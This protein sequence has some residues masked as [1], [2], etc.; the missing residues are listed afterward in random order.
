M[1][2]DKKPVPK[3]VLVFGAEARIGG[4]LAEFLTREA[5]SVRLRLA[6]NV[7]SSVD[8]LKARY[9]NAEVVVADYSDLETLRPAVAG[10][11]GV[12]VLTPSG[13]DERSMMTNLVTALKEAGVVVHVI[14]LVG[15]QPESNM[16]RIPQALRDHGLALPI[17]HPI[18]KTILDDSGLPVTYLNSGATF[19]DNFYWMAKPLREQR[20]LIWPERKIPYIDPREIG[21]AAGRLL[22]SD[23]LRH[24]GQFHTMN[25][26]HDIMLFSQAAKLMSEVWGEPIAYEGSREAFFSAYADRGL[27]NLTRMWDFFQYEAANDEVWARNDFMERIL[28]RKPITLAQW[29]AEHKKGLLG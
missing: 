22:L 2:S 20:T 12:F 23:N 7:A 1:Q 3:S 18:A 13:A 9:P 16:H 4:P 14:R 10:M 5:P 28:G 25:N 21:E 26:G 11:E 29:L 27:S 6:T 8:A 19:M 17:Q 15:M 24:V